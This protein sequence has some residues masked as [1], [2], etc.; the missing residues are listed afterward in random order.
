MSE[1]KQRIYMILVAAAIAFWGYN[2]INR[3]DD[4]TDKTPQPVVAAAPS[5]P[6]A[7]ATTPDVSSVMNK[8]WA[9]DPF[10][11]RRKRQSRTQ[12]RALANTYKLKAIIYNETSPSAF[13]N[14][15]VVRKG[16]TINGAK[17]IRIS[18]RAVTVEE[19]GRE[20]TITVDRG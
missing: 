3:K 18:K 10:Y 1:T 5:V 9:T 13:L 11:Q 17:V 20:I 14:G 8:P 2:A 15:R 4:R 6:K 7:R 19:N 16:D 12:Q